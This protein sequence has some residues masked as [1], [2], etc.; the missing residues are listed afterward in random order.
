MTSIEGHVGLINLSD[1]AGR[2][3]VGGYIGGVNTRD[4]R[5]DGARDDAREISHW[6][7][8]V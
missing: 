1:Y 4:F 8:G 6:R 2:I 7:V 3:N 5:E